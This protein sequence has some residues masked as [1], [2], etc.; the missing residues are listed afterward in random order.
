MGL[1][2]SGVITGAVI[3]VLGTIQY[4][5]PNIFPGVLYYGGGTVVSQI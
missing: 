2:W 1:G 4:L 3:A 5:E